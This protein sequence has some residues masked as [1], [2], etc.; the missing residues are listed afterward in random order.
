MAS[1]M[2]LANGE[3]IEIQNT[4]YRL[5]NPACGV[6]EAAWQLTSGPN[7]A[8]VTN[9]GD[10]S[11]VE[12]FES[13]SYEFSRTC[14]EVNNAQGYGS[15]LSRVNALMSSPSRMGFGANTTGGAAATQYT[16]VTSLADSGSGTLRDALRGNTPAWIIFDE[17]IH[18]GTIELRSTVNVLNSDITIDGAG[19]DITITVP[20]SNVEYPRFTFR[21]GNT[22]IHGITLDGNGA[23][24]NSI[25][26]REGRNYW[27]DHVTITN[28]SGDDAMNVGQGNR[29]D[30]S[31]SE[32]TISNYRVHDTSFGFLAGGEN[33]IVNYPSHRITIHSS[34]LGARDRNP[35]VHN[36]GTMHLLNNYIHS[37]VYVGALAGTN[38]VFYAE[39]NIISGAL[40]NQK[41]N[42]L[43]GRSTKDSGVDG[44]VYSSGNLLID[45]ALATVNVFDATP[46]DFNLP[47]DYTVMPASAVR[48]YVLANAGAA[49]APDPDSVS[50]N[51]ASNGAMSCSVRSQTLVYSVE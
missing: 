16:V 19:A 9:A 50:S 15:P 41:A 10:D 13:G 3:A 44:R 40:A 5:G 6:S 33:H 1:S 42:A 31:A 38:T 34:N 28:N 8:L 12:M 24:S 49:N 37:F 11:F 35:R 23:A 22:I 7:S 2:V 21:G 48:D 43:S 27:V 4:K 30:L 29:G 46:E 39:N 25:M 36:N 26:M 51:N 32:V 14:C 45:G 47:Y 20:N 18:G 17:S